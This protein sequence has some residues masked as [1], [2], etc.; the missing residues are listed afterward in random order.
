MKRIWRHRAAVSTGIAIGLLLALVTLLAYLDGGSAGSF[1]HFYYIPIVLASYLLGDLGGIVAAFAAALLAALLPLQG[2]TPQPFK[3]ILIR[4]VLFYFIGLMTARLF[5]KLEERREDAASLLEVSR[6]VNASLRVTEVLRTITETAVK[7]TAAK[8][9]SIRLLNRTRDELTPA[10]SYGLSLDYLAKGPVRLAQSPLD[11]EAVA[12]R[13]VVILD[14]TRDPRFHYREEARAEGLVSLLTLPLRRGEDAFGVLRVYSG[15]RHQ[16][17]GRERRLLQAFADQAAIAIH[18]A[19]LHEDLR[20][21]YWE[22]V[23]ALARAIEAK[24][25]HTLGHS[26][27]VTDYTLQLGRALN[28][29]PDKMEILRFAAT[30]H[31]VGKI[32]LSDRSL[33]RMGH[34]SMNDEV[35]V[36]MH[37]LIGISILQPVEFLAPVLDAVRYHHE[38]WDGNGYP[39]GL[40]A[41]DIPLSARILGVA[42][43]YDTL[44]TASPGR[45]GLSEQEAPQALRRAAGKELDPSLVPVFLRALGYDSPFRTPAQPA[46]APPRA[47]DT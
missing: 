15:S 21:S 22:T 36:R 3:D 34:L 10:A 19:R 6:S 26:E 18:N 44:R 4:G 46:S 25:P 13:T 20:R 11:Q 30:L 42:N 27:R 9:S 41:E 17:S 37:P 32:G 24:D 40:A 8:A 35:L 23:N 33:A 31:D 43:L 47:R 14:I 28:L 12:G 39:E 1:I 16:W 45:P 2:S 38:R 7:I 29:S 5:A